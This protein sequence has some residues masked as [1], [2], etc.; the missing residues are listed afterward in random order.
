MEMTEELLLDELYR[1]L[2]RRDSTLWSSLASVEL[3]SDEISATGSHQSF[4]PAE[5]DLLS[6]AWPLPPEDTAKEFAL[7]LEEIGVRV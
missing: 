6:E 1:N 2:S 3:S 4:A 7:Y 5:D